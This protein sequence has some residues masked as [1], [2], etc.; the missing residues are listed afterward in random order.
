MGFVEICVFVTVFFV[1]V[2]LSFLFGCFMAIMIDDPEFA[3]CSAWLLICIFFGIAI[4]FILFANG[5]I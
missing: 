3:F 4:T 1:V 5:I 2:F